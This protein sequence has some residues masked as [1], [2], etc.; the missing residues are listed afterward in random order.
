MV[1][2]AVKVSQF[3]DIDAAGAVLNKKLILMDKSGPNITFQK[4]GQ[5]SGRNDV[6]SDKVNFKSSI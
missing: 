2:H 1:L 6:T 3:D 5:I 4:S